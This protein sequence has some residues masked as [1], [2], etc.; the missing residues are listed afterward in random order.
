MKERRKKATQTFWKSITT[1]GA[2]AQQQVGLLCM[3]VCGTVEEL[4]AS[5]DYSSM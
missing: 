5:V 3:V 1:A 4:A 2:K